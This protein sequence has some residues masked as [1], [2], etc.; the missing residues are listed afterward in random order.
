MNNHS[1]VF[2]KEC[3]TLFIFFF[4]Q[5]FVYWETRLIYKNLISCYKG[6]N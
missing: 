2:D 1:I 6:M 5:D 4:L 3:E